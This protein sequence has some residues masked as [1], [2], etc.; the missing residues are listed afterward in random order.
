VVLLG[1]P[2]VRMSMRPAAGP[3][4]TTADTTSVITWVWSW[5]TNPR[6]ARGSAAERPPRC[7]C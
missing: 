3:L 7:T 2:P 6:N 5:L 4:G 1:L